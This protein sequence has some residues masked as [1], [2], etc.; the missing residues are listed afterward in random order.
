MTDGHATE[1]HRGEQVSVCQ[2]EC[3]VQEV[4]H[5]AECACGAERF[6]LVAIVNPHPELRTVAKIRLDQM[7]KMIDRDDDLTNSNGFHS[8]QKELQNRH[9]AQRH[10]RFWEQNRI[11]MQPRAL[12]ARHYD[13]LAD[14]D[15]R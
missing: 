13:R 15:R 4:K 14:E 10:Q 5:I 11:R 6:V 2:K 12:A 1:V 3:F 8:S 9:V 7:S